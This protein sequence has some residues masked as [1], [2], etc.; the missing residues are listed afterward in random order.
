M[1]SRA[2]KVAHPRRVGSSYLLSGLLKCKACNRALSGQFAYYVCQSIMERGKDAC[3]TPRL[4]ARRFEEMV[5]AKIR[6]NIL[7]EG[8]ITDLV[9]AVDDEMDGIAGE[10]R[11]RLRIIEDELEGVKRRLGAIW[12]FI[13][14]TPGTDMSDAADRIREHRERKE[15]LEDAAEDAR[16]VLSERRAYRDD[17]H[18]RSLRQGH[19]RLPERERVDRTQGL[20]QGDH[21]HTRR[22]L[23][24]LHRAYAGRQSH[25]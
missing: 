3:D 9:K 16:A 8:S 21:R 20:H 10:Q 7:T 11:K 14:T 19:E 12:N 4:N 22:R 24:A 6:S 2:P 13:E 15:R 23:A 1:R 5:V 25:T 18:H 17:G